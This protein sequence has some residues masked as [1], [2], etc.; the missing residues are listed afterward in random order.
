MANNKKSN[1][2]SKK[3][4]IKDSIDIEQI[5][6]QKRKEQDLKSD[7]EPNKEKVKTTRRCFTDFLLEKRVPIASFIYKLH[8]IDRNNAKENPKEKAPDGL[9]LKG[10]TN[11]NKFILKIIYFIIMLL[12]GISIIVV[13]SLIAANIIQLTAEGN[14]SS[15]SNS[16]LAGGLMALG[17][18]ILGFFI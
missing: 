11:K 8:K 13:G 10:L 1:K 6:E 7:L 4:V 2:N 17:I 5:E 3:K 9:I 16:F 14:G 12:I 18:I 15:Q